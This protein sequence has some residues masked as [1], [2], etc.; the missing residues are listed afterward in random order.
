[1]TTYSIYL[2]GW[3][4]IMAVAVLNGAFRVATYG[5]R[6]PGIRAHQ[7][8]SF[9]AILLIGGMTLLYNS[10]WPVQSVEQAWHIGLSWLVMTIAFEFIFGRFV[11][12]HPWQKLVNDYRIDRGRLWILVLVW[13]TV[14]PRLALLNN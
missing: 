11:M 14:V 12:K 9:S 6:M 7:L 8:S 10:I 1:M 2:L 3:W 5:K 4:G 13:L